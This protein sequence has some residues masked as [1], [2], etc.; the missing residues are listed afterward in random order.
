MIRDYTNAIKN[1]YRYI[2]I[3]IYIIY[4]YIYILQNSNIYAYSTLNIFSIRYDYSIY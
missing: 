2:Y 3:Y 4:I 1:N